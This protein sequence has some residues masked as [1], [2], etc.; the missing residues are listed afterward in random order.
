MKIKT[1]NGTR[2]TF[3]DLKP[4]DLFRAYRSGWPSA[5]FMK[6]E[7][8]YNEND[9]LLNAVYASSGVRFSFADEEPVE[10]VNGVF[11]EGYE[12]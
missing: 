5:I 8:T 11:V 2:K 3:G 6:V 4:G 9:G 12:E 7:A 1:M 10:E